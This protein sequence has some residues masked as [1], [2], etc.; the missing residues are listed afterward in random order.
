MNNMNIE[1]ILKV[2]WPNIDKTSEYTFN[3]FHTAFEEACWINHNSSGIVK[4]IITRKIEVRQW[5]KDLFA[6]I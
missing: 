2:Y 5:I 3:N 1:Y 4:G 6:P